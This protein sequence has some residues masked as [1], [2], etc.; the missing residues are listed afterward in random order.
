MAHH[1]DEKTKKIRERNKRDWMIFK[2]TQKML[3]QVD[4]GA[5]EI[6]LKPTAKGAK[7]E[8][9]LW[10]AKVVTIKNRLDG[11][12][13]AAEDRWNRCAGTSGGGGRGR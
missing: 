12:R 7:K 2:S 10:S 8:E 13:R 9:K 11:S 5:P 4:V 1:E 3:E 6:E